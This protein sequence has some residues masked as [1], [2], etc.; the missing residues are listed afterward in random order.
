MAGEYTLAELAEAVELPPRTIRSYIEQGLLRGPETGGRG[1]RYTRYHLD[2]LKAI[3]VLKDLRGLSITDV[4][5][6]LLSLTA[7]EIAA[8]AS[9]T[10]A[11]KRS[12][13]LVESSDSALEY[14]ELI[15]T[16]VRG[17]AKRTGAPPSPSTGP[18]PVDL[19]LGRLEALTTGQKVQRKARGEP[20]FRIEVTPEV[21]IQ[22]RGRQAA[23]Q[24]ARWERIAD[25]LRHILLGGIEED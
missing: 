7:E 14:L 1:A 24:L 17:R 12:P 2:R 21:E 23:D 16:G 3:R 9:G 11:G 10:Q 5:S 20:W 19:L 4:R 18:T 8:L 6:R 25:H 22:V 15:K 13:S